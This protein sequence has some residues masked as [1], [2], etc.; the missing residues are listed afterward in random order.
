MGREET[1]DFVSIDEEVESGF[2]LGSPEETHRFYGMC[3]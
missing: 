1:T 3:A 2:L